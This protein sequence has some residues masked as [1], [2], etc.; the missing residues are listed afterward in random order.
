MASWPNNSCP[1]RHADPINDLMNFLAFLNSAAPPTRF[2]P[3]K[4]VEKGKPSTS[5]ELLASL[6]SPFGSLFLFS[7]V[8]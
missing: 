2:A 4:A 1:P 3:N 7:V 8:Q 5:S 6:A